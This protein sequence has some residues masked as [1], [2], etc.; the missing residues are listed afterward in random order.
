MSGQSS[1]T[2]TAATTHTPITDLQTK[3]RG[4]TNQRARMNTCLNVIFSQGETASRAGLPAVQEWLK[5]YNSQG[6]QQILDTLM[7]GETG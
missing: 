2:G 3:I 1:A 4:A 5:N 6:R 7:E